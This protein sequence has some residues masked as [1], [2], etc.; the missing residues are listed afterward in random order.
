MGLP[1]IIPLIAVTSLLTMIF[2]YVVS[3]QAA[4]NFQGPVAA[5]VLQVIDGDTFLAHAILWPG[6]SLRINIRVRGIDTPEMKS[7]CKSEHFA[8]KQARDEL[9]KLLGDG[10]VSISNI[11]GAKYYGRV[12]AD[13][14]ARDG[15]RVAEEMILRNFARPYRGGKREG[16][17]N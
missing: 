17:C 15:T 14:V 2:Q 10:P 8:A 11:A 1:R 9:K 6:Q 5:N 4:K 7:R 16:W 12:L 3:V 13:V